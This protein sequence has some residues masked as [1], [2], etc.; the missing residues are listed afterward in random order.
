MDWVYENIMGAAIKK[1][2]EDLRE[3]GFKVYTGNIPTNYRGN[4]LCQ[5]DL[6]AESEDNSDRRIY[7]LYR[8]IDALPEDKYNGLQAMAKDIS[9]ELYM[10]YIDIPEENK[11]V[12][13]ELPKILLAGLKKNKKLKE[14]EYTRVD[15][16]GIDSI[17][18][19]GT[20]IFVEGIGSA[21]LECE[22]NKKVDQKEFKFKLSYKVSDKTVTSLKCTWITIYR[23][24]S[25]G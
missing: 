23:G 12:F 11:I 17:E 2:E 25:I 19:K 3:K 7:Q 24:Q 20:K 18:V 10:L 13:N 14:K 15:V 22:N 8:N 6:F 4:K 1:V 9:A 21:Y 5:V 16:L